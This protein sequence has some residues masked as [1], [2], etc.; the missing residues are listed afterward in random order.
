MK[1]LH[2]SFLREEVLSFR[3]FIWPFIRRPK[4]DTTTKDHIPLP[5]IRVLSSFLCSVKGLQ[6]E[7]LSAK[8]KNG[9]DDYERGTED[10]FTMILKKPIPL[11]HLFLAMKHAQGVD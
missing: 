9:E 8:K 1:L 6:K 2:L 10:K 5:R 3:P 11:L 4:G 7:L